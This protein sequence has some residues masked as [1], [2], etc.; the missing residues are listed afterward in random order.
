MLT[1][2]F[3][4]TQNVSYQLINMENWISVIFSVFFFFYK[5]EQ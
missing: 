2:F 1:A 5:Y 3:W 4:A